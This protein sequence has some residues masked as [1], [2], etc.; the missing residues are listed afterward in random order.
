MALKNTVNSSRGITPALLGA[1]T[2]VITVGCVSESSSTTSSASIS[3]DEAVIASVGRFLE[4][5]EGPTL[6]LWDDVGAPA[7]FP[8]TCAEFVGFSSEENRPQVSPAD[9]GKFTVSL[10]DLRQTSNRESYSWHYTAQT[11]VVSSS[12]NVC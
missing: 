12:Q 7:F 9:S 5:R 8:Q 4:S 1:L 3:D 2:L 10:T 11:D 6:V